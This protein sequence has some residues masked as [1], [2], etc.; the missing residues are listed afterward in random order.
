MTGIYKIESRI[1][2]DR[3]YIGSA[4]DI[5]QRWYGHKG[6]LR[7]NKHHSKR[8]QNHYNKYGIDDLVFSIIMECNK[9]HLLYLEQEFINNLNPWFNLCK[10]AGSCKGIKRGK[11][12][13]KHIENLSRS[14][15]GKHSHLGIPHSE[16]TKNN[17]SKNHADMS[18]SN[19][20][21]FG[22][23]RSKEVCDKLSKSHI[24][25]QSGE[26]H[27]MYNKN[28]S[29]ESKLTMRNSRYEYLKRKNST[30]PKEI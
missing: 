17:I 4:I 29:E 6:N 15:K 3:L 23:K 16:E 9:D 22:K 28:H 30:K 5:K 7:N 10:I 8:L 11:F 19:N 21:S 25:I 12:S 26:N 1:R 24:G 13:A 20:P 27:P 14:H 2:P 18:G